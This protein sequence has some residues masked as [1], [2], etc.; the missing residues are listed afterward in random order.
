MYDHTVIQFKEFKND[1]NNFEEEEVETA[2][3]QLKTT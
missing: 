1:I 3:R 2:A